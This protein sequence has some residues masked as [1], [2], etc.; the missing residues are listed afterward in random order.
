[1]ELITDYISPA[2]LTGF[3][4]AE[5][6]QF[7]TDED[8]NFLLRWFPVEQIDD[9]EYTFALGGDLESNVLSYRSYDAESP[10]GSR[11]GQK[12]VKGTIPPISEK[13]PLGEYENLRR[14]TSANAEIRNVTLR[15]AGRQARGIARRLE[16]ARGQMLIEGKITINENGLVTEIEFDRDPTHTDTA[17]T[18]WS[19][20]NSADPIKD[21]SDWRDN[22]EAK[23]F[24][25]GTILGSREVVNAAR[26][27]KKVID[28]IKGSAVSVTQV[29][30]D[31]LN[32]LLI[33]EG[34]PPFTVH[35]GTVGG[36]RTIGSTNIVMLPSEEVGRTL[37]G[38]TAEALESAYEVNLDNGEGPGIVS[39]QY[40]SPDP[41]KLWTKTAG[42]AV[43]L[44]AEPNATLS[45][46]VL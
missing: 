17:G 33:S 4:R 7:H 9:V 44:F 46:K 41:V 15:D 6:D 32:S 25:V 18:L 28:A 31:E 42:I 2:E 29:T 3:A 21:L 45:G 23:G 8:R 20:S 14:R 13:I 40:K 35:N 16:L 5:L 19:T 34:L 43:P 38:T 22:V 11:P 10:L 24:S 26:R 30:L 39:G 27:C 1:M 12:A 36:T 37:F